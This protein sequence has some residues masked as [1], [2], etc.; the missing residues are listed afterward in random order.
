MLWAHSQIQY[1]NFVGGSAIDRR[2]CAPSC[3][4]EAFR[5]EPELKKNKKL[6]SVSDHAYSV[7]SPHV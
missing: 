2:L 6:G 5:V 7:R 3:I 4:R 1:R